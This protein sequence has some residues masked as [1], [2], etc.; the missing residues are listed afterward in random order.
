MGNW[1]AKARFF[2]RRTLIPIGLIFLFAAVASAQLLPGQVPAGPPPQPG[3]L[4]PPPKKLPPSTPEAAP[5]SADPDSATDGTNN[6]DVIRVPVRY[7]LVP[8]TV[9]DPDGHGYVNGLSTRDFE[10]LDNGKPQKINSDFSEQPLSVVLAVQ[11]NAV[12]P[13]QCPAPG[14]R[15][16]RLPVDLSGRRDPV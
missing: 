14:Y 15:S 1:P 9:L 13:F 16:G 7:V 11:A 3:Q 6:P 10:L 5:K 8:T 4:G 2:F 12:C